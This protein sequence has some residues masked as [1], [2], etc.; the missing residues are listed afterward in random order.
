LACVCISAGSSSASPL[1]HNLLALAERVG[2]GAEVSGGR[3]GLG[4]VT[5]EHGLE[6]RSEDEVGAAE[7]GQCEPQEEDELESVVEGEPVDDAEQALK[8]GEKGK[9]DPVSEPLSVVGFG[10]GEQSLHGVVTRND[11][12]SQVGEQLA[13][14]VE[15]D[16]EEVKSARAN[17]GVDLRNRGLL[18]QVVE[19]RVFGELTVELAHILLNTILSR[20][21]EFVI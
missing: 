6:E 14:E 4:E 11:E 17:N 10:S 5:A 1:G 21:C 13:A 19:S 9:N 8:D 7:H 2:L 12:T 20:H 18:L 16:K 3:S 15:D